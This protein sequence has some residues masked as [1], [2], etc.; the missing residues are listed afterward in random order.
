MIGYNDINRLLPPAVEDEINEDADLSQR[1]VSLAEK[2]FKNLSGIDSD[3]QYLSCY[4]D[5]FLFVCSKFMRFDDALLANINNNF[6][7]ASTKLDDIKRSK[8]FE[9]FEQS[10]VAQIC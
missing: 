1:L 4:L 6:T 3:T 10:K 5:V 2:E 7:L 8:L 9:N